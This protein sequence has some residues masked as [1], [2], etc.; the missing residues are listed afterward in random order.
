MKLS[1]KWK[2]ETLAA[3]K[4]SLKWLEK[5]KIPYTIKKENPYGNTHYEYISACCKC[6]GKSLMTFYDESEL[7]SEYIYCR[8]CAEKIKNNVPQNYQIEDLPPI[9]LENNQKVKIKIREDNINEVII[10]SNFPMIYP[11]KVVYIDSNFKRFIR[12][13]VSRAFDENGKFLGRKIIKIFLPD[14]THN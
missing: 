11:D 1:Y 7:K 3:T 4:H 6:C 9:F 5:Y 8:S 14:L 2:G 13:G 12:V 10:E